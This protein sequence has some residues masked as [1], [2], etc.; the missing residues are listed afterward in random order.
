MKVVLQQ[1][2]PHSSTAVQVIHVLAG[3]IRLY[4]CTCELCMA[5]QGA[6]Q[7]TRGVRVND[8]AIYYRVQVGEAVVS[9]GPHALEL[10][11]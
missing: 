10:R 11:I 8:A 7:E 2:Q 4:G 9:V 6:S 1:V 5:L 3:F